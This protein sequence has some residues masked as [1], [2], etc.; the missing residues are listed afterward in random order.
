[1]SSSS[2]YS[3]QPCPAV[4]RFRGS[5]RCCRDRR[6]CLLLREQRC[7]RARPSEI[8][9]YLRPPVHPLVAEN[10]PRS[11]RGVL[12]EVKKKLT[13]RKGVLALGHEYDICSKNCLKRLLSYLQNCTINH[14]KLE[15]K[16]FLP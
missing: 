3:G 9:S 6:R 2:M 11:D 16:V 4:R 8:H 5:A 15:L 10:S 7:S 12:S 1:M 14:V 13:P